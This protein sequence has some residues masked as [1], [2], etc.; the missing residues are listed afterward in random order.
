MIGNEKKSRLDLMLGVKT[1][2]IEEQARNQECGD[3]KMDPESTSPAID[4]IELR[5]HTGCEP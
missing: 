2:G 3:E 5:G 4:L 1:E